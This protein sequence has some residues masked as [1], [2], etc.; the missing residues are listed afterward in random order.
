MQKIVI[1][2]TC[3]MVIGAVGCSKKQHEGNKDVERNFQGDWRTEYIIDNK[4][5]RMRVLE[6]ATFDTLNH[7]YRVD[8]TLM[9]IYPVTIKYADVSYQGTWSADEKY[10]HGVIDKSSV[11]N[12]L[13][14]QF[15]ADPQVKIYKDFVKNSAD[16]DMQKDE[17]LIREIESDRIHL[18]DLDRNVT[19][20]LVRASAPQPEESL[21]SDS[22][23]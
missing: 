22:A 1:G 19:H 2:V 11:V 6:E 3:L 14:S 5:M 15:D 4:D 8:Q 7:T 9:L 13:N 21:K 23:K 10:L 12:Q 17:F 16:A 18:I 20:D